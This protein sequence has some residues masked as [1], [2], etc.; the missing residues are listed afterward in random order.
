ME[1][2]GETLERVMDTLVR[3]RIEARQIR[4]DT[5][6]AIAEIKGGVAALQRDM[7]QVKPLT[8]KWKRWQMIGWGVI[9][10]CGAL[11]TMVGA[12]LTYFKTQ[13]LALFH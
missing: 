1:S 3:D 2:M 4:E 7:D 5:A 13:I 12:F 9:L 10:T 8:E 6:R 11:G